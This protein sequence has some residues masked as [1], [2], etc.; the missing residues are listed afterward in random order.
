MLDALA[1]GTNPDVVIVAKICLATGARWSEAQNLSRAQVKNGRITYAKTKNGK[2]RTVPI[3]KALEREILT[4]RPRVGS[5]FKP[6]H[7]AFE[8]GLQRSK[9]QLPKG[10]RTHVLRHTFA[11]QYMMNG[12]DILR[13]SKILG[14]MILQMTMRYAHLAPDHLEEVVTLNPL[15]FVPVNGNEKVPP[16]KSGKNVESDRAA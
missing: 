6:C 10:Q 9:I 1:G 11:S 3:S 16:G 2:I 13:L 15:D 12:G 7:D 5:L 14:H 4:G 8:S